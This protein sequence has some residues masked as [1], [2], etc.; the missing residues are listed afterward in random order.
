[1]GFFL[2]FFNFFFKL[3]WNVLS[4]VKKIKSTSNE[5]VTEHG[6]EG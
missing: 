5:L 4:Y 2:F 3:H 1:M 6:H